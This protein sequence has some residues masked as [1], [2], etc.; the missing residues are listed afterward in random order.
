M[1]PNLDSKT[2]GILNY[3]T[4]SRCVAQANALKSRSMMPGTNP[5]RI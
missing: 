2:P 3:K 4:W 5:A 1:K